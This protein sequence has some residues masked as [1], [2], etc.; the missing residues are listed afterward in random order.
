MKVLI[1][2]GAGFIGSHIAELFLNHGHSVIVIDNL[3]SACKPVAPK[4]AKLHNVDIKDR[5]RLEGIFKENRPDAVIHLAAQKSVSRSISDPI[6]DAEENIIGS[7]TLLEVARTRGVDRVVF[8]STGGVYSPKSPVPVKENHPT[9]PLSPYALA[10]LTCEHYLRFYS[11][12]HGLKTVIFRIA[13]VY[14]PR[15]NP[16]GE[17]GVVSIFSERLK[18]SQPLVIHGDGKQTRDYVYVEDV[19]QAFLKAVLNSKSVTVNIGT[20]TETSLLELAQTLM[21]AVGKKVPIEFQSAKPGELYRSSLDYST[22]KRL[23][24]WQPTTLLVDGL[25][26]TYKSYH[27]A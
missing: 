20:N 11:D 24:G 2:G 15:Q 16:Y 3:S 27:R 13:N 14:G 18:K 23:F 25:R 10:K 19:A 7:L 12:H 21:E 22:A 17:A 26:K 1:T 9:L 5:Q 6:S 4:G 8:P